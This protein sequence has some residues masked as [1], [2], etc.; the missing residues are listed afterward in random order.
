MDTSETYIKMRI[1]ALPDLGMGDSEFSLTCPY[2]VTEHVWVAPNG[3]YYCS[4]NVGG[5]V[6]VVIGCQLERQDQLQEMV[7]T[8]IGS[9]QP[10]FKMI[11]ELN[12]FFDY[13]DTNGIPNY[14]TTWEQL[15]LAFVMSERYQ[16]IWNG[17]DWK[18]VEAEVKAQ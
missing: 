14:L 5:K 2:F 17:E 4:Q 12:H 15:W 6:D 1:A 8:H 11:S 3:N 18:P 9:T 13:W 10:N 16:K 7:P